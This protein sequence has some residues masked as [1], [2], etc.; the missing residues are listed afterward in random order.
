MAACNSNAD[1]KAPRVC[2]SSGECENPAPVPAACSVDVDCPGDEV[3]DQGGCTA[4]NFKDSCGKPL[5]A[6]AFLD[7]GIEDAPLVTGPQWKCWHNKA[8]KGHE[9]T[10]L[11]RWEVSHARLKAQLMSAGRFT[12]VEFDDPKPECLA[13]FKRGEFDQP[14]MSNDVRKCPTV[15]GVYHPGMVTLM[16]YK[17]FTPGVIT[18]K[19]DWRKLCSEGLDF[20]QA[21][22]K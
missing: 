10:L 17:V 5:W 16:Q 8:L 21:S 19:A 4:P 13:A 22:A 3:C 7:S 1:C 14:V 11:V 9:L 20:L 6:T 15:L 12:E 2:G 18:S